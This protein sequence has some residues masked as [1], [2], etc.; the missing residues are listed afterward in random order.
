MLIVELTPEGQNDLAE[1]VATF[2]TLGFRITDADKDEIQESV[3][4]QFAQ[5]FV[6]QRSRSGAWLPLAPITQR[7]R[8]HKGFP[9]SRPILERRGDYR[10]SVIVAGH[11]DHF[12]QTWRSAQVFELQ[13]GGNSD[14]FTFHEA[15]TRYMP[16]RSVV[17]LDDRAE[18]VI[19][20]TMDSVLDRMFRRW[21]L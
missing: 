18:D 21:G 16:A 6:L 9:P 15:G 2:G 13:E 1:F 20:L 8:L 19:G 7:D 17:D 11:G 4:A 14:L 10:D 12:S 3:L 5:S